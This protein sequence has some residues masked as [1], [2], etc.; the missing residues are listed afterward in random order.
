MLIELGM[1]G[2]VSFQANLYPEKLILV[3]ASGDLRQLEGKPKLQVV[4]KKQG[5]TLN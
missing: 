3:I 5:R 4:P 1:E 2:F